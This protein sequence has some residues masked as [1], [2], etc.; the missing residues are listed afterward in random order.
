MWAN[1]FFSRTCENEGL[2]S[3]LDPLSDF[4]IGVVL[5]LLTHSL[6]PCQYRTMES[7]FTLNSA[8]PPMTEVRLIPHSLATRM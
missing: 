1:H 8:Y 6:L 4:M 3:L 5:A 7:P 2:N